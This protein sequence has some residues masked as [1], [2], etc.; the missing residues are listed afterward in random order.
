MLKLL[1]HFYC[2]SSLAEKVNA[3]KHVFEWLLF[4]NWR[5]VKKCFALPW[6]ECGWPDHNDRKFRWHVFWWQECVI[7]WT[8][9][10]LFPGK[11]TY[12]KNRYHKLFGVRSILINATIWIGCNSC[13][14]LFF[15][16]CVSF[17]SVQKDIIYKT[18]R[19]C[20]KSQIYLKG[21]SI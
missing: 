14:M 12:P 7:Y 9:W 4:V 3:L 21:R 5:L 20:L 13:N 19:C 16:V 15:L 10:R 1:F 11:R 6:L 8:T 17:C 18:D 2:I